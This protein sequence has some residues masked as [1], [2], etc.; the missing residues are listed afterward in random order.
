MVALRQHPD[1]LCLTNFRLSNWDERRCQR[2]FGL[3]EQGKG[4]L[5]TTM[6]F[7]SF[8]SDKPDVNDMTIDDLVLFSDPGPL[9]RV[10]RAWTAVKKYSLMVD[11]THAQAI[12]AVEKHL[13]KLPPE[14]ILSEGDLDSACLAELE[15]Q[16]LS[17]SNSYLVKPMI[18]LQLDAFS[19]HAHKEIYNLV[20]PHGPPYPDKQAFCFIRNALQQEERVWNT[21]SSFYKQHFSDFREPIRNNFAHGAWSCLATNL[22]RLDLT[23]TFVAVAEHFVQIKTNLRHRGIG[24]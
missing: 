19:D 6:H 20:R 10:E 15:L 3:D 12:H 16:A 2:R 17:D 23:Q 21:D 24:A 22:E 14:K 1:T 5:N 9:E 13:E 7:Q 8:P 11:R 4:Q 18:F